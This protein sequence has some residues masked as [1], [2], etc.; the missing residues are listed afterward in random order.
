[1]LGTES[2]DIHATTGVKV[3]WRAVSTN[4]TLGVAGT[5][6]KALRVYSSKLAPAIFV[7]SGGVAAAAWGD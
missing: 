2:M 7:V 6:S 1:M 4:F 3:S 5:D